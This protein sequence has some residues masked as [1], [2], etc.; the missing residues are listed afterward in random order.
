VPYI[1]TGVIDDVQ[2]VAMATNAT[3]AAA[4][5]RRNQNVLCAAVV[6]TRDLPCGSGSKY[7]NAI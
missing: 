6:A 2:S 7:P 5:A 4:A 3:P 1:C